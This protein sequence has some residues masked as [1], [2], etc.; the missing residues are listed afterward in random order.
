[1]KWNFATPR[2]LREAGI[3]GMNMRNH[4]YIHACNPRANYP[5]VDD[6]L[7][8]KQLAE[9]A[10]LAVP[11]MIGVVRY[12][13]EVK[14]LLRIIGD[15][16][17]FVI[18]PTCG[19][20]GRGIMVIKA[21]EGDQFVRAS[22]ARTDLATL[23]RHTSNTLSGL[24]SLGGQ[25][26]VALIEER[27]RFSD[28]FERYSF[29]GV[30]DVRIIIYKGYPVMAMM[31]LSTA[32]SDGKAN[33]HQGAVGVGIDIATGRAMA[34]AQRNRPVY[35][36]PDTAA[37]FETLEVP[38]W[39]DHLELAARCHEFIGLGYFG[40]DIVLDRDRGP[41]ILELNARP[42]LSIQIANKMGLLHRLNAVDALPQPLVGNFADRVSHAME[43]FA[44]F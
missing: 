21:R 29:Q 8:T 37:S 9:K 22:G 3:L 6:K 39:R 15:H 30:P 2:Q 17:E 31:R 19:S 44:S 23:Q 10:G 4:A 13:H 1:M 20:G 16:Q 18:K 11:R 32:E 28:L 14:Q 40:A 24:Y 35:A 36:H 25:H 5:R 7:Q 38:F 43:M 12:Q 34:A 27:I 41:M 33:L 42:G 26:D